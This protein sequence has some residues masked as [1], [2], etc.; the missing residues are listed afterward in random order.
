MSRL[1]ASNGVDSVDS[2]RAKQP[3]VD[4]D[5]IEI[6]LPLGQN[7]ETETVAV[8]ALRV[9]CLTLRATESGDTL[10]RRCRRSAGR[11]NHVLDENGG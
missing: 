4:S 11:A 9:D 8:W 2:G 3:V 5:E 1:E 6:R 10:S 7:T